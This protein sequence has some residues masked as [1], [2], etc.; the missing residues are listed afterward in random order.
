MASSIHGLVRILCCR[1]SVA[2]TLSITLALCVG[3]AGAQATLPVNYGELVHTFEAPNNLGNAVV[4]LVDSR[5]SGLFGATL[6]SNFQAP[7]FWNSSGG[8][9]AWTDANLG[10]VF[11]VTLDGATNPNIYVTAASKF[12]VYPF[13]AGT[14][15]AFGPGG[16]GGVYR[17]NG[18]TGAICLLF[19]LPSDINS[20]LGNITYS[21]TSN[22]LYVSNLA[23]GLIYQLSLG[24]NINAPTCPA[25]LASTYDHGVT[26]RAAFFGSTFSIADNGLAGITQPGRR[27]WGVAYNKN[28]NRL[29]YGVWWED[30]GAPNPTE[31]NEVW[32]VALNNAGVPNITSARR[33]FSHPAY[34][35]NY[36]SPAAGLNFSPIGTLLVGERTQGA[37][38]S[39]LLEYTGGTTTWAPLPANKYLVGV[40]DTSCS[41]AGEMEWTGNVWSAGDG[42]I[43]SGGTALYGLMRIPLGGNTTHIPP[44]A[45]SVLVDSDRHTLQND[46][47]EIGTLVLRRRPCA[48]PPANM[49]LWM[50]FDQSSG[51][52]TRN[53][54]ASQF[55]GNL[56]GGVFLP[57]GKVGN[58]ACFDQGMINVSQY[59]N[60]Q[61]G[62]DLTID[63]WVSPNAQ[64][65]A[66]W[67]HTIVDKR[68]NIGGGFW[69]G[70]RLYLTNAGVLTL[71]VWAS[72][73]LPNTFTGPTLAMNSTWQHIAVTVRRSCPNL[74]NMCVDFYKNGVLT[75]TP[76]VF[77]GGP[78]ATS[79]GLRI[80]DSVDGLPNRWYVGCID[81]LEIFNRALSAFEIQTVWGAGANGKC[82][83][84]C[85]IYPVDFNCDDVVD[86]F[87]YL[88]FVA[89]FS[90]GS[91]D[92]DFN[93]DGTLDFFDYL[94]FVNAFA[95]WT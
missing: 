4:T 5:P 34:S 23:N 85:F 53:L 90:S 89:V 57:A 3:R 21:E 70:Y 61:L 36:S 50:P 62:N 58:A 14:G 29:Y 84:L 91:G 59:P 86:F 32:S 11:G 52:T 76:S 81:E 1:T 6:G 25:V 44:T 31:N 7:I 47:T 12:P 75:T 87:D 69:R 92:A 2:S 17:L 45:N 72:T 65:P 88:D 39:R 77:I 95:N 26:G 51:T 10:Q 60:L 13:S 48:T 24:P 18:T 54:I 8:A 38:Q 67:Q 27:V 80:G 71:D 83:T 55:P 46:K 66:T 56:S 19:S 64:A 43:L 74:G 73:S 9:N 41:G 20:G 16:P 33:E 35:G 49:V 68:Q 15:T 42:I 79:T 37:H 93:G 94:D 63:A 78:A 28:E 30:S 40:G 82:K 22:S